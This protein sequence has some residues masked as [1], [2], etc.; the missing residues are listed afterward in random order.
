LKRDRPAEET[1]DTCQWR[2]ILDVMFGEGL[3]FRTDQFLAQVQLLPLCNS[4]TSSVRL[5]VLLGLACSAVVI[6][7][8]VTAAV[9]LE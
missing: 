2:T 4:R 7:A 5:A 3:M 9:G 1:N 6:L 8:R